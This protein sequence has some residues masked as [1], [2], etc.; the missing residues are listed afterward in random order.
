MCP[1]RLFLYVAASSN[2]Y[3]IFFPHSASCRSLRL[4][5]P[6]HRASSRRS[7]PAAAARSCCCMPL[8]LSNGVDGVFD[9][10]STD[11]GDGESLASGGGGGGGAAAAGEAAA[12]S[13]RSRCIGEAS[14][15]ESAVAC[16]AI[17][18][19]AALAAPLAAHRARRIRVAHRGEPRCT[20][21]RAAPR[22]WL[23][24]PYNGPA[25]ASTSSA[26]TPPTSHSQAP[27]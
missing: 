18:C 2:K 3:S 25:A 20:R 27:T 7:L 13:Q 10:A 23:A 19:T 8:L 24:R 16:S 17:R 11:G 21:G 12:V 5:A 1:C 22:R 14:A 4:S 26:P 6:P 15:C 9:G